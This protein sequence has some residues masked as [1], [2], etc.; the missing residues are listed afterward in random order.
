MYRQLR[1]FKTRT[2]NRDG[3]TATY[4]CIYW[5]RLLYTIYYVCLRYY[6]YRDC[7]KKIATLTCH[8]H[9]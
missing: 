5:A 4:T 9:Q 1:M 3:S 2:D 6:V 7:I 8:Q